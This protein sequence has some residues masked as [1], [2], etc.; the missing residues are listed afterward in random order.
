MSAAS[1]PG[2]P[3]PGAPTMQP[4]FVDTK[5]GQSDSGADEFFIGDVAT[6]GSQT[7][8]ANMGTGTEHQ[9][10]ECQTDIIAPAMVRIPHMPQSWDEF[11]GLKAVVEEAAARA[12]LSAT[13]Q[14][15]RGTT[16]PS[17]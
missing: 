10:V 5:F 14:P 7:E 12:R 4:A 15:S 9:S 6:V 1:A 16:R 11:M 13:S 8:H 17:P 2:I 3:S